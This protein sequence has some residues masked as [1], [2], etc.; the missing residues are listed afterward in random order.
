[1]AG[2]I[3]KVIRKLTG[4]EKTVS[5]P[6]VALP[7]IIGPGRTTVGELIL[8][9]LKSG[10]ASGKAKVRD[11]GTPGAKRRLLARAGYRRVAANTEQPIVLG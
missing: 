9:A 8:E 5:A 6:N 7:T 4:Q 10:P 11:I 3:E 2:I 1:M